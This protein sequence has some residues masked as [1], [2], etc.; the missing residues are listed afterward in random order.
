[1]GTTRLDSSLPLFDWISSG[2]TPSIRG[3]LKQVSLDVAG[4][5][6]IGSYLPVVGCIQ[7]GSS[8]LLQSLSRLDFAASVSSYVHLG[9]TILIRSLSYPGFLVPTSQATCIDSFPFLRRMS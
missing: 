9:S 7:L 6:Q 8:F 2:S 4:F 5:G 3:A 1:F